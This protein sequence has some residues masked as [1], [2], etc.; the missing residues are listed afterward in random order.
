MGCAPRLATPV[1]PGNKISTLQTP[2]SGESTGSMAS[3]G[4]EDI[5]TPLPP[6]PSQPA[7]LGTTIVSKVGLRIASPAQRLSSLLQPTVCPQAQVSTSISEM[8]LPPSPISETVSLLQIP[9]SY[10]GISLPPTPELTISEIPESVLRLTA[11][12]T[13]STTDEMLG[14]GEGSLSVDTSSDSEPEDPDMKRVYIRLRELRHQT[15][16]LDTDSSSISAQSSSL[17]TPVYSCAGSTDAA[18]KE[19]PCQE[20][21]STPPLSSSPFAAFNCAVA[22]TSERNKSNQALRLKH[23]SYQKASQQNSASAESYLADI[24]NIS[25]PNPSSTS[26]S[27]RNHSGVR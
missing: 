1:H 4:Y 10:S 11:F 6:G 23:F 19:L 13:A 2:A 17:S 15:P 7:Y 25:E 18:R 27:V 20:V 16:S 12:I 22:E 21:C 24:E 8:S 3:I 5:G 26:R 9:A 14:L